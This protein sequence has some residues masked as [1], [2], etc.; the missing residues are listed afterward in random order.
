MNTPRIIAIKKETNTL[1]KV[2]PKWKINSPS[3]ISEYKVFTMTKREGNVVG[4][5]KF[6]NNSHKI[7]KNIKEN[8]LTELKYFL[9]SIPN[10][11]FC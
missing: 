5:E 1:Y 9:V 3:R 11:S 10:C 7:N 2:I 6:D 4:L 8:P